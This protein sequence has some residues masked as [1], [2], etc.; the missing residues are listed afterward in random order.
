MPAFFLLTCAVQRALTRTFVRDGKEIRAMKVW[1]EFVEFF[2]ES[3]T[4]ENCY[5][6]KCNF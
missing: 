5:V 1:N 4:I 3:Y 6:Q 2:T